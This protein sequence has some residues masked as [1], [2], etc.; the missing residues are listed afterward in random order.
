MNKLL[1]AGLIIFTIA[2]S[3]CAQSNTIGENIGDSLGDIPTAGKL[4]MGAS[5]EQD[6]DC[7]YAINAY[8]TQK[9]ISQNCPPPEDAQP[10]IGDPAYE[11]K[12]TYLD[13]CVNSVAL[14]GKNVQGEELL[15]DERAATCWCQTIQA[16]GTSLNGQ[17]ICRKQVVETPVENTEI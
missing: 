16:E 4:I 9:C 2:L 7:V 17:K 14:G 5:C 3:G 13:E 15:V 6:S 10:E 12:Q 11:W 1:F 8:P